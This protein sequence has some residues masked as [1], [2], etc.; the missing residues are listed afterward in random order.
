MKPTKQK[1]THMKGSL[2]FQ[3]VLSNRL[4]LRLAISALK[5]KANIFI[6]FQ[7]LGGVAN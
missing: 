5:E 4:S 7:K 2:K 6:H 1:Q 3:M